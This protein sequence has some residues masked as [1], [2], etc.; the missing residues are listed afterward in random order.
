MSRAQFTP[1]VSQ[2]SPSFWNKLSALKLNE[3][4]LSDDIIHAHAE[5]TPSKTTRDRVTGSELGSRCRI[6]LQGDGMRADGA[7]GDAPVSTAYVVL[8]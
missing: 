6:R 3:L 5:Y 7:V 2:V 1:F 4:Q 8:C